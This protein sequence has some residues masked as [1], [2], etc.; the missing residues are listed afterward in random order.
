MVFVTMNYIMNCQ[1]YELSELRFAEI[2]PNEIRGA[3]FWPT[4]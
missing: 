3:V 2:T 4:H 1:N